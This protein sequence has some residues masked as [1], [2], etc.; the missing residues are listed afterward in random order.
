MAGGL[1][2]GNAVNPNPRAIAES[3]AP[4]ESL[5]GGGG[6]QEEEQ[7]QKPGLGFVLGLE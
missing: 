7:E 5:L 3:I 6:Q 4:G 2:M 1:S